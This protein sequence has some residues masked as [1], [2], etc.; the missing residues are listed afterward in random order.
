VSNR[1][2]ELAVDVVSD[3][4]K[5]T[6]GLG[7][8]GSV[9]SSSAADVAKLGNESAETARKI[10]LSAD[11]ADELAGK[12]GKATGA[13]GAL[14]GG[15]EAVGLEK[16]AAGLQGAAIATDF[17]S[18]AGDALNLVMESTIVK[19]IQSR[20]ATVARTVAEKAAATGTAVMTAGQW[21]L[22][23]AMSANPIALVVIA[24][25]A[26]VAG[27]VLAYKKSATVRAIVQEVGRVGA[28]AIGFVVDK[29]TDLI[30]WV[31]DRLPAAFATAKGL[32]VGYLK[33]ITLPIRTTIDVVQSLIRWVRD[34]M[35]KAFETA[36]GVVVGVGEAILSPFKTILNT[37][38][39]IIDW[40]KK[41][42]IPSIGD[43]KGGGVPFVPGVRLAA[44]GSS[45]NN[46]AV[47]G[48]TI[49]VNVYGSIFDSNGLAKAVSTAVPRRARRFGFA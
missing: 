1:A 12:T 19:S 33:L 5:A 44:G 18:G 32:V 4:T 9:A 2:A 22:N 42:D 41:I 17:A 13:L 29:V 10:G 23:A 15:L 21:A 37:V 16:F 36:K 39:D 49:N 46:V 30:G 31:G 43:L 24:L 38:K 8:V 6:S 27:L 20:A 28:A 48:D 34:T 35:P 26:L 25:V 40:I 7:D 45:I 11:S 3:V 14:S 47:G